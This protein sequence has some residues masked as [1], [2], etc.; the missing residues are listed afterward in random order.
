M[1]PSGRITGV[2]GAPLT[3]TSTGTKA[4]EGLMAPSGTV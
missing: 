1:G 2:K 4:L 3:L